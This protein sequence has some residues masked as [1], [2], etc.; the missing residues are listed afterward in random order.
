M[1]LSMDYQVS[2]GGT[3]VV[4]WTEVGMEVDW[5][6]FTAEFIERPD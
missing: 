1:R 2:Y 5:Y 3:Y 4:G 6:G